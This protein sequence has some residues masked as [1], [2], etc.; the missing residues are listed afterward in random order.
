M[1]FTICEAVETELS[2]LESS[3]II[4]KVTHTDWAA[5][6]IAVPKANGRLR[7]TCGDKVTTNPVLAVDQYPLPRPEELFATLAGG[8]KFSKIDLSQSLHSIS[9]RRHFCRVCH[10]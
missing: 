4:E 3:G 2:Q 8:K 7:R 9:S 10:N 5:P 6:I 1:P